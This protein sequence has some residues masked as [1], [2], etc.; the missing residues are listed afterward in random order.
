MPIVSNTSPILN[1]AI[2]NQLDLLR[3]QFGQAQFPLM[4][5]Q[6]L[7]VDEDRPSSE[8]IR[9]AVATGWIQSVQKL[10]IHL[11]FSY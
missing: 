8:V 9:A 2:I 11:L 1:L 6:E 3:E 4:V 7:K 10:A 5:L